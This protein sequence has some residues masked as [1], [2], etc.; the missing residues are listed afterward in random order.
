MNIVRIRF[1]EGPNIFIHRPILL[2][3]LDLGVYTGKESIDIPGLGERLLHHFPGLRQHHCAK[4]RPGGFIERLED[5]TYFGHI[6]EHVAIEIGHLAG[7]PA[8][9][10]KTVYAGRPGLYDVAIECASFPA[11]RHALEAAVDVVRS[12]AEGREPGDLDALVREVARLYED[13]RLGPS[14]QAIVDACRRRNIPVRRLQASFLELGYGVHRKRIEATLTDRTSCVAADIASDKALT[15]HLLEEAGLAVP[16]GGVAADEAEAVFL[17]RHLGGPAV[18]KPLDARQGQGVSLRLESEAEVRAAFREARRYAREVIVEAYVPGENVRA[19]VVDGRAVAASVR[20]PAYVEG[21]G[22]HTVRELVDLVNLDPRRGEGHEKPLTKIAIDEIARQVLLRQGMSPESVPQLGERVALRESANLSTGGEARDVTDVLHPSYLRIAERAA[23]AV[24][25]DV[26]GVD[27]VVPSL[28]APADAGGWA[29]IEVNACPGIRM[30]EHPS[31]GSPRRAAEAIVESLFPAGSDG[32][33]P[34]VSITGTNGKTTTARLVAHGFAVAGKTVGLTTTGGVYVG[35]E[36]VLKGDT[37]GPMSARLVLS[38]PRVEVAVLETA[39]GGIVR[40]GLAYD[41]ADVGVITN[42]SLDHVGQDG[43]ESIDDIAFVKA[44]VGECVRD[45]GAVVLNADDPRVLAL[46][47]RFRARLVLVSQVPENPHVARH[48]QAGGMA[49]VVSDG[50]VYEWQGGVQ[51]PILAVGQIPICLGGLARFHVENAA[52]AAAAMRAGG[53]SRS[54]VAKVLATF[55]PEQNAGR[56]EMYVL[57]NGARIVLDYGHNPAGFREVGRWLQALPCR[58]RVGVV[59][60]PGDR[61]DHVVEEAGRALAPWF[62]EF[63]VKEDADL[64]GRAPGEIADILRS[65]IARACPEKKVEVVPD[66]R[67]AALAAAKALGPD[68]VACVFYER[69]APLK[70]AL[71]ELGARPWHRVVADRAGERLAML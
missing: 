6:C 5:G 21:D 34:I 33:I 55:L 69:L 22:V 68:D 49:V 26:C 40:G 52:L 50:V 46:S 42:I 58:R 53:L 63:I 13:D 27:L 18:V 65:S 43:L 57:P 48:V 12:L 56:L 23:E 45:D 32:R 44:L 41:I 28:T 64:R 4:G 54:T 16:P 2:A 47:P 3:R 62:D 7:I 31:S 35:G 66:E 17:W 20:E 39:R 59:G 36:C 38:N 67:E 10:G 1:I 70:E 60:V 11:Q 30:H 14:T 61:A 51:R 15:K 71:E 9:Y 37:T 8:N 19:L 29:V 24:G 25:L